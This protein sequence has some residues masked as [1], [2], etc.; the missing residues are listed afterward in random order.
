MLT[1]EFAAK[2]VP[3]LVRA[4]G[5]ARQRPTARSLTDERHATAR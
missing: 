5:R 2:D 3:R 4:S 1:L